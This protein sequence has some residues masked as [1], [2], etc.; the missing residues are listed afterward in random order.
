AGRAAPAEGEVDER[1]D[2]VLVHAGARA[3]H[4][5][6]VRVARDRD[7]LAHA[8]ELGGLLAEPHL[9]QEGPRVADG[10]GPGAGA[11]VHCPRASGASTHTASGSGKPVTYAKSLSCR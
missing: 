8:R 11:R 7:R 1:L 6:A 10:G 5:L 4:R 3:A 9:V 2:L